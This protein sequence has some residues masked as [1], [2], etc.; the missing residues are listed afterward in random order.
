MRRNGHG[1]TEYHLVMATEANTTRG[2][3]AFITAAGLLLCALF[4]GACSI[5]ASVDTDSQS[6]APTLAAAGCPYFDS[7]L[8][9]ELIDGIQ[10]VLSGA[11]LDPSTSD[12]CIRRFVTATDW[13]ELE[14]GPADSDQTLFAAGELATNGADVTRAT[15]TDGQQVDVT[16]RA[17]S[18]ASISTW[19]ASLVGASV[20]AG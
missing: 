15:L 18:P 19:D 6:G 14:F 4:L 1:R 3:F 7:D 20:I 16:A 2:P 13:I 8:G 10:A 17:S 5:E 11:D 9:P 12:P